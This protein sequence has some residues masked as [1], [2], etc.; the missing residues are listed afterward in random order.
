MRIIRQSRLDLLEAIKSKELVI[1][2]AGSMA[3][4][5]LNEIDI[6]GRVRFICDN[7]A[8]RIGSQLCGIDIVTAE[9]LKTVSPKEVAILVA[10]K[11]SQAETAAQVQDYGDFDTYFVGALFG[12]KTEKV[13]CELYDNGDHIKVVESLLNDDISRRTYREVIRRRM[14]YGEC[15]FSDLIISESDEYIFPEMY[16]KCA[17][18]HEI[19]LDCGAYTGDSL[20]RFT[21]FFANRADKI[22]AFEC[23]KVQLEQLKE[24]AARLKGLSYCPEIKIMPYAVSDRNESVGF[25]EQE[26]LGGSFVLSIDGAMRTEGSAGPSYAVESV[27]LDSVIPGDERITL[28]KMDIEGSEYSA[29]QG[30]K[31]IIQRDKPRLA[32]SLYHSGLDYFRLPLLLKEFVP[33]YKLAVRHYKKRHVDTDLYAWI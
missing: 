30:A 12:K 6:A 25:C 1:F 20:E 18:S 2:G 16:S 32:I 7:A 3:L 19:I 21:R 26:K 10:T 27:S 24:R 29:L 5:A 17:P 28:I 31:R 9:A 13:A 33:E 11:N 8:D 4:R 15:D 22:Y 14:L 23:G